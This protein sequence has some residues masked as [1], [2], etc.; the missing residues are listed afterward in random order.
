M[1]V[2][3]LLD[4]ID[5]TVRDRRRRAPAREH[6]LV[7]HPLQPFDPRDFV[8]GAARRRPA[9]E[10]RPRHARRRARADRRPRRRAPPFLARAAARA[11]RA[12]SSSSTTSCAS[13]RIPARAFLR[14]RLGVSV[15]D[16]SDESQDVLPVELDP[17]EQWAVGQR[18]LDALLAGTPIA[19]AVEIEVARGTL[20]PGRL[21]LPV[22]AR[23]RPVAEQ[24]AAEVRARSAAR[25]RRRRPST[26]TST[27]ARRPPAQRDGRRGRRRRSLRAR[28]VLARQPERAPRRRG[29]GCWRSRRPIPSAPFEALTIGRAR[30]GAPS[31]RSVTIA[32]IAPL[33]RTPARREQLARTCDSSTC[34]T[35]GCAS[36]CRSRACR[37]PRTRAPRATARTPR[38]AARKQWESALSLR[39]R[40]RA[41]RAPARLRRRARV[42]RA[43]RR[44]ARATDE[45]GDGLGRGAR[46]RASGA[47]RGGCGRGLLEHEAGERPVS[48]RGAVRRLRAAAARRDRARGERRDRQDVHDRRAD[49]ALRRAGHAAGPHAARDVHADGDRRAARPRARAARRRRARARRRRCATAARPATATRS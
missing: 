4:A 28:R 33:G 10:L 8:A 38:E 26:S 2:G 47:T 1:P 37:P 35:A 19:D 15:G 27:L 45:A 14:Q 17:L 3:E 25:L 31:T 44:R 41:A 20:P 21:A 39:R 43:A 34:A 13:S 5:A 7:R 32:R 6:V 49:G 16:F 42:R 48:E 46:R 9:V 40:G 30:R 36:R 23:V 12:R 11:R 24:I 18:L 29:C 22:L